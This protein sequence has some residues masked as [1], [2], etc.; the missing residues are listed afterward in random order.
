[1]ILLTIIL[2]V[3]M[4]D[5]QELPEGCIQV[6]MRE[7]AVCEDKEVEECGV[8]QTVVTR[9]CTINMMKVWVPHRYKRCV[10]KRREPEKC[11]K[12]LRRSCQVRYQ[13]RCQTKM[14][15]KDMEEDIPNCQ[16]EKVQSCKE[17]KLIDNLIDPDTDCVH[18]EVKKCRIIRRKVR[19]A[20]PDTRCERVPIKTCVK[21]K[22]E[23]A[24]EKCEEVVRM[25]KE[26]Q[27]QESCTFSPRRVCQEGGEAACRT[28]VSRVCRQLQ[29]G[30]V[31]MQLLCNGTL[32]GGP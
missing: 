31:R 32:Q 2:A 1:M 14:L 5:T 6:K 13:T 4:V 27:P 24:K 9:D 30:A 11:V 23:V 22:C 18:T 8:C 26:F 16:L 28:A 3:V 17:S 19:K 15:Y 21:H 10:G 29:G 25:V 7:E 12:G 20:Q